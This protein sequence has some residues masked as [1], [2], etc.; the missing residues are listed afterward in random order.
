MRAQG[1]SRPA[2]I[3]NS[4]DC[5]GDTFNRIGW[6][7]TWQSSMYSCSPIL[8]S[9]RICMVSPQYGHCTGIVCRSSTRCSVTVSVFD[10]Y[11]AVDREPKIRRFIGQ[12]RYNIL[13]GRGGPGKY[14]QI[15]TANGPDT[16]QKFRAGRQQHAQAQSCEHPAGGSHPQLPSRLYCMRWGPAA[17]PLRLTKSS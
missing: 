1:F 5:E 9:T 2:R 16:L 14:P 7:H 3:R 6:Q 12:C 8:Q 17:S 15:V 13:A 4:P 11:Q 10:P